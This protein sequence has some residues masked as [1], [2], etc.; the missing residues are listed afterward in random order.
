MNGNEK[1]LRPFERANMN[2]AFFY[3]AMLFGQSE[4]SIKWLDQLAGGSW[5]QTAD[6]W[7]TELTFTRRKDSESKAFV[8]RQ[9]KEG[10]GWEVRGSAFASSRAP[11]NAL[12]LDFDSRA[13]VTNG[14]A[15]VATRLRLD[16]KR[17]I[18]RDQTPA[19]STKPNRVE[20][21]FETQLGSFE[22]GSK[23][24][25]TREH[26]PPTD[27]EL[28]D[29]FPSRF[30]WL[31]VLSKDRIARLSED[32]EQKGIMHSYGFKID[33]AK[34][35]EDPTYILIYQRLKKNSNGMMKPE[36]SRV[37][38][39][40]VRITRV[41]PKTGEFGALCWI[42]Q[43]LQA[44][45][46]DPLANDPEFTQT[47]IIEFFF[48][49]PKGSLPTAQTIKTRVESHNRIGGKWGS[50]YEEFVREEF[51]RDT[52]FDSRAVSKVP[53]GEW[54]RIVSTGSWHYFQS[55]DVVD[56]TLGEK[57]KRRQVFIQVG[58]GSRVGGKLQHDY[59]FF[60]GSW[61]EL[62]IDADAIRVQCRIDDSYT[63]PEGGEPVRNRQFRG[64]D[65]ELVFQFIKKNGQVDRGAFNIYYFNSKP[66]EELSV[67]KWSEEG[68]HYF[69][70]QE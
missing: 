21:E 11:G 58:A 25:L 23:L 20:I 7:T 37:F 17:I 9:T 57:G 40:P 16:S 31:R 32:P 30:D 47:G 22:K 69:S 48:E 46:T 67:W 60:V 50:S 38:K 59:E 66:L 44:D 24:T 52:K 43:V 41:S 3:L 29:S 68:I 51:F 64:G 6:G 18:V 27:P 26:V 55:R 1:A 8:L 35:E 49:N 39:G 45:G 54:E 62:K 28:A 5:T 14:V 53:A 15:S 34:A 36:F 4:E 56:I 12:V 61:S 13:D 10:A 42:N 65:L 2:I 63:K 19:Q 70:K 33:M